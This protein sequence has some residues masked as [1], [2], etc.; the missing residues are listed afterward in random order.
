MCEQTELNQILL[1]TV[2][3][4]CLSNDLRKAHLHPKEPPD[5][6]GTFLMLNIFTNF[7]SLY[8]IIYFIGR[9]TPLINIID[10]FYSLT[11]NRFLF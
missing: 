6:D 1:Q 8:K 9:V 10:Q 11:W 4:L 5:A 2:R 3:K 7:E